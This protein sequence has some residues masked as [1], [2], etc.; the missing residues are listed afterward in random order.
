MDGVNHCIFVGRLGKVAEMR[1]LPSGSAITNVSLASDRS[2]KKNEERVSETT[3]VKLTGFG[4]LAEIMQKLGSK[5]ALWYVE[6]RFHTYQYE[7]EGQTRYGSDFIVEKLTLLAWGK[8]EDAGEVSA[9][10]EGVEPGAEFTA[11]SDEIPF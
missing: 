10:I 1:Y 7:A 3:W 11:D 4:K 5:G 8:R 9:E 6:T 2:Y